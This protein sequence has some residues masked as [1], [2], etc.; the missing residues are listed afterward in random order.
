MSDH[1]KKKTY[2][3]LN[4]FV[5]DRKFSVH[6]GSWLGVHGVEWS[7]GRGGV[8]LKVG[9]WGWGWRLVVAVPFFSPF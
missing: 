3:Y 5:R 4:I 7:G 8:V 6:H 2:I 1:L 9:G